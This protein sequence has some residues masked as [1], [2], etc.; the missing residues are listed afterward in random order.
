MRR[1][2]DPRCAN[3]VKGKGRY[4][5]QHRGRGKPYQ[6]DPESQRFYQSERWRRVRKLKL[7][8]SPLCE[9]CQLKG[10]V[11]PATMVHHSIPVR[12]GME[13][14]LIMVYLVSCCIACHNSLESELE[15]RKDNER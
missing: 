5:D 11:T 8:S 9:V 4:C 2:A 1:C 13:D 7:S 3:L 12:E 14:A 10:V 15:A 6:R